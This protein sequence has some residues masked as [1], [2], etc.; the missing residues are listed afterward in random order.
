MKAEI[1][2]PCGFSQSG[3]MDGHCDAGTVKRAFGCAALRPQSGVH[4]LPCQSIR[5]AGGCVGHALPPH[6]AVR[7]MATLVKMQLRSSVA[8][9]LGLDLLRRAGRDAEEAV[10]R[11]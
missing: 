10:L 5:R 4:G 9:A 1:G 6:V 8:M 7:V 3:S 11:D 2:T